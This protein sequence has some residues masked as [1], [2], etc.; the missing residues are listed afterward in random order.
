MTVFYLEFFASHFFRPIQD[1]TFFF[2]LFASHFFRPI[3]D[4][5]FF[6]GFICFPFFLSN[7]FLYD[8]RF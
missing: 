7:P 2:D 8:D 3:Q 6:F 5:S 1:A 4:A